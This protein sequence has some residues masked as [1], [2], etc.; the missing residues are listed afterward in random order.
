MHA[1][2]PNRRWA[3]CGICWRC[4]LRF[5]CLCMRE[6]QRE[7]EKETARKSQ[8]F[9]M[10]MKWAWISINNIVDYFLFSY[11]FLTQYC[12]VE[13]GNRYFMDCRT[14][15]KTYFFFSLSW[16]DW[17]LIFLS[18]VAAA[19]SH[20]HTYIRVQRYSTAQYIANKSECFWMQMNFITNW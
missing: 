14:R 19:R 7:R 16:I 10:K 5:F 17:G 1:E 15:K 11:S 6:R 4:V 20:I 13:Y 9:I 3:Q 18:A 12:N 8:C 2:C